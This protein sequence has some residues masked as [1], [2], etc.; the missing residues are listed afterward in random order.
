[1]DQSASSRDQG[2]FVQVNGLRMYYETYGVGPPAILLH[3]GLETCRMWGPVIPSFSTNYQGITPDSRGHG[4]TDN[5]SGAFSFPLLA[6]DTA[7]FIQVL[8]LQTPL[9]VGYSHGG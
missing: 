8:G 2:A 5:S 7:L 9:V 3:G 4:R 6:Q 1:M